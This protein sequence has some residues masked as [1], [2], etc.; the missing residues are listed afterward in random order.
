MLPRENS[1]KTPDGL[2]PRRGG[3]FIVGQPEV[4]QVKTILLAVVAGD[5][6][7]RDRWAL[8]VAHPHSREEFGSLVL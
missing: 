3:W 8:L 2:L 5:P 4:V 6:A 1:F 7:R